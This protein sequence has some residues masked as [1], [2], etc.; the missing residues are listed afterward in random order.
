MAKGLFH[1]TVYEAADDSFTADG[2][3]VELLPDDFSVGVCFQLALDV[4]PDLLLRIELCNVGLGVVEAFDDESVTGGRSSRNFDRLK[5]AVAK[6]YWKFQ[7]SPELPKK[8]SLLKCTKDQTLTLDAADFRRLHVDKND[9]F[10]ADQF[11]ELV[12]DGQV[13]NDLTRRKKI[14]FV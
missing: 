4:V 12:V 8:G 13:A 7:N 10:M 3:H 5:F 11:F 6:K 14:I 2:Q 9:D 1:F